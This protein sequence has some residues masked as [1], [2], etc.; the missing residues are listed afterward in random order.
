MSWGLPWMFS[1]EGRAAHQANKAAAEALAARQAYEAYPAAPLLIPRLSIPSTNDGLHMRLVER[2]E[3]IFRE[4]TQFTTADAEDEPNRHIAFC[5]LLFDGYR[6][7]LTWEDQVALVGCCKFSRF[8]LANYFR[9]LD[10]TL[11]ELKVISSFQWEPEIH[12]SR[13]FA[14]PD[15]EAAAKAKQRFLAERDDRLVGTLRDQYDKSSNVEL[16]TLYVIR[17]SL[18][19]EGK[20]RGLLAVAGANLKLVNLLCYSITS[21][22][23]L[24]C[25]QTD[26]RG[27]FVVEK[28]W[29]LLSLERDGKSFTLPVLSSDLL[30]CTY[31]TRTPK[32]DEFVDYVGYLQDEFR[33]LRKRYQKALGLK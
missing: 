29:L 19:P 21:W 13:H 22:A 2:D 27:K 9:W 12:G 16:G 32:Q 8:L 1:A 15:A 33:V 25:Y 26:L 30:S 10:V 24:P 23:I 4:P 28:F 5:H 3:P 11:Y 14:S 17:F 20:A 31:L 7:L 6:H 18:L